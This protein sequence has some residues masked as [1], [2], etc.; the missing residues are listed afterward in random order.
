MQLEWKI[1][2]D[3]IQGFCSPQEYAK[4]RVR[5]ILSILPSRYLIYPHEYGFDPYKVIGQPSKIHLA[6]EL[7]M[8]ELKRALE[9]QF[10]VQAVNLNLVGS[11]A[12]A[13]V[14]LSYEGNQMLIKEEYHG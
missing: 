8:E 10:K 11:I 12:K 13:E 5:H 1:D 6:T 3:R 7:L 14:H 2:G 4:Q 9:P